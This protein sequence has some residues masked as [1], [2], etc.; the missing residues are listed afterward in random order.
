[1]AGLLVVAL[2]MLA[3]CGGGGPTAEE[4]SG[5]VGRWESQIPD[6]P[7]VLEFLSNGE[8]LETHSMR[9]RV[10]AIPFWWTVGDGRVRIT[11][12][13]NVWNFLYEIDGSTVTFTRLGP[14][15]WTGL[16]YD[17]FVFQRIG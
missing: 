14:D 1:M 13:E 4:E 8:G 11:I 15:I 16:Y 5:L 12:A 10:D 7:F 3:A 17:T 2:L 9:G 6:V